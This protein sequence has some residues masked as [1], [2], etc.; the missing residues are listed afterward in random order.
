MLPGPQYG[1]TKRELLLLSFAVSSGTST[2]YQLVT[3]SAG[4][5]E[6]QTRTGKRF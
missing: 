2:A 3:V 4:S 6:K 1:L 5:T